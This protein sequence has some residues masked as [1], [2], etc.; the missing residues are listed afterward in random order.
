MT[1]I[2]AMIKGGRLEL[3]APVDWPDGTEVEIHPLKQ[4]TSGDAD[5]MSPE[6]IAAVLAAM[7]QVVPL[8]FTDA[9]RA[10]WEAERNARKQREKAEFA[11]HA[12]DLRREWE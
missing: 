5:T 8:E 4:G 10:A 3:D 2:R 9:E 12:H 11:Q 7:D 1:A 6:Q